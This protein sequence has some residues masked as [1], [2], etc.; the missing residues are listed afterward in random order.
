MTFDPDAPFS[1]DS[2]PRGSGA[3]RFPVDL[4]SSPDLRRPGSTDDHVTDGTGLPRTLFIDESMNA[5]QVFG[6]ASGM[7][8]GYDDVS[9]PSFYV[10]CAS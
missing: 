4:N 8:M 2:V 3:F 5:H 9:F 10:L 1:L 6:S 7:S